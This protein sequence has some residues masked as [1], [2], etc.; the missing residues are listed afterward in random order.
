MN[1][2]LRIGIVGC[3]S[4]GA[5]HARVVG[6]LTGATLVG[7]VD[8]HADRRQKVAAA[9]G[10][11]ALESLEALL[12]LG[13]DAAVVATP[14]AQHHAVASRLIEAGIHVL[15]EKPIAGTVAAAR[16]LIE[17]A[18]THDR[19]LMIGHV[20]RFNPAL[21]ALQA[22]LAGEAVRSIA[23]TRAGPFPARIGD[24][25]I[26]LDLGVHDIDLIRW[27]SGSEIGDARAMVSKTHGDREDC[28]FLQFRTESGALAS[29]STNWLTPFRQR[30]ME[31]ATRDRFL[32][33]DMLVRTV[34]EYSDYGRDGSVRRR[35]LF[36][37]QT[38]PLK[39]EHLAFL[40]AIRGE[41]DVPVS[42]RDGLR[43]LEIALACLAA[44]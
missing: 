4:M 33:C 29:I 27:I 3:G 12:A 38:E 18:A 16:N 24:V 42:G 35:D 17:R 2:K 7:V 43:S 26:V 40:A 8:P 1:Q 28:A 39:A 9:T 34:T 5:N 37:G 22:A 20:E 19:R 30:R 25:G 13:I 15:V 23:I 41:A 6:G 11:E 36:V 44:G 32:V 10:C 14:T 31:V 21:V